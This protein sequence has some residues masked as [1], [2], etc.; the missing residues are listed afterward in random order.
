[1]KGGRKRIKIFFHEFKKNLLHLSAVVF[2]PFLFKFIFNLFLKINICLFLLFPVYIYL[3]F[4]LN[5]YRCFFSYDSI[6]TYFLIFI[7]NFSTIYIQSY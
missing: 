3:K 6:F 7:N 4:K 2:L 5:I 1:M